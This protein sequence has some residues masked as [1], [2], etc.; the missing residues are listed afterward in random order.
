L[1]LE[2]P[3]LLMDDPTTAIDAQTEAEVL[4]A[5]DG[6][7]EGRTTLIVSGRL[8]T[9]RR[10]DFIVVLAGGRIVELGTHEA[11]MNTDGLY[12]QAARL[13]GIERR[14]PNRSPTAEVQP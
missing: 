8:S 4:K 13:Q 6:A 12:R 7:I 2:P 9:L 3:I 11:L 1:L 14:G 10:A 5:V